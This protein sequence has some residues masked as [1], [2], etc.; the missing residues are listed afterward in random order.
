M[1][2]FASICCTGECSSSAPSLPIFISS[3]DAQ[4]SPTCEVDIVANDMDP[5]NPLGS[6]ESSDDSDVLGLSR[7]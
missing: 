5:D 4:V 7:R 1:P 2:R 3:E 6:D